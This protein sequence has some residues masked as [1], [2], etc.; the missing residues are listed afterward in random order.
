MFNACN[1]FYIPL[2]PGQSG[3]YLFQNCLSYANHFKTELLHLKA[4]E[5]TS[6]THTSKTRQI[7][8]IVKF[9][10]IVLVCSE[11]RGLGRGKFCCFAINIPLRVAC[12]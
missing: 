7:I 11:A 1:N 12:I 5:Q 6:I 9:K 3:D 10:I 4:K 2:T 8:A